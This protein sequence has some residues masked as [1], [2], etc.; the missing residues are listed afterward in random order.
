MLKKLGS[1]MG[2]VFDFGAMLGEGEEGA[3]EAAADEE[4]EEEEPNL[5]A[6]ASDGECWGRG[7]APAAH[8]GTLYLWVVALVE[9]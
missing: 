6:A 3:E 1:A 9:Q 2:D 8:I 5:H 4:E 7:A